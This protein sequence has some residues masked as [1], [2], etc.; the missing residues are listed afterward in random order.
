MK[1]ITCMCEKT[2]EADLPDSVDLDKNPEYVRSII[3]GNFMSVTCPQCGKLLKP[4]FPVTITGKKMGI[5]IAY[6]PEIERDTFLLGKLTYDIGKPARVVIGYRELVE[7]ITISEA[8]FDDRAIELIKYLLLTKAVSSGGSAEEISIIFKGTESGSLVFHI[9][10]LRKEEIAITKI[11]M[12]MYK[13]TA[14]EIGKKVKE[15]P[16]N[17]FLTPP[18]VSISKVD[19]EK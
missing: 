2:F 14:S 4:D 8:G 17:Q 15:E 12:D 7:K 11:G 16:Y 9:E 19:V 10:G 5:D 18:Y 13:K 6:V 3:D 1:E